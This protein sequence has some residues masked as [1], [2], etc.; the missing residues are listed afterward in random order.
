MEVV[1]SLPH[2][3]VFIVSVKYWV[4]L[5]LADVNNLAGTGVATGIFAIKV[6]FG[7]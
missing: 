4:C 6:E 5:E 1:G 3:S 2:L 7:C